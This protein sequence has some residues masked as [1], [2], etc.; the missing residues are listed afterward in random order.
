[1]SEYMSAENLRIAEHTR[2]A[3]IWVLGMLE[4]GEL[5]QWKGM[6]AGNKFDMGTAARR[7]GCGTAG[8]IAGWASIHMQ[9]IKPNAAGIYIMTEEQADIASD[10][11]ADAHG[12]LARLF[13]AMDLTGRNSFSLDE[14]RPDQAAKALRNYLTTGRPSWGLIP[15]ETANG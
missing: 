4:A 9:G 5:E 1:M 8:C 15:K 14:V 6:T 7:T 10:F 2:D 12:D 11:C 13:Y 3:L